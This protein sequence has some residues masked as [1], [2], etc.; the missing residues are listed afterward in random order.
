MKV[1]PWH[2]LVKQEYE[3][4]DIQKLLGE[5]KSFEDLAKKYS[6]CSSSQN[7][8]FLGEVDRRRLN[9]DF[10]EAFE[11][12][13]PGQISKPVRT[14]FGWHLIMKPKLES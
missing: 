7:G 2:I 12:L 3:A 1:K 5:G 9:E 6:I 13:K 14:S 10:L 11:L 8:G 4:K